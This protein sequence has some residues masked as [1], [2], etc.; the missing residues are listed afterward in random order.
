MCDSDFKFNKGWIKKKL[1]RNS[2][3]Y[4]AV[5]LKV[6]KQTKSKEHKLMFR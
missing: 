5:V 2:K 3:N 6:L 4:L 1:L